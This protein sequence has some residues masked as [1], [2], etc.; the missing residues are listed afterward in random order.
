MLCYQ[1]RFISPT[2]PLTSDRFAH[3]VVSDAV[4][5]TISEVRQLKERAREAATRGEDPRPAEAA[6]QQ[7]KRTLPMIIWQ[8]TFEETVSKRGNRGRWRKQAAARLNGLYMVDIDHVEQP[9]QLFASWWKP[10]MD[11]L[12][13]DGNFH[14]NG[15]GM[16]RW[17]EALGVLLVHVTPSGHGL[18]LVAKAS[19]LRGNLSDNQHWLCSQ[20]GTECDEAC[21][22][23]SRTSFCPGF[24]DILYIDN[25]QLFNYENPEYDEKF[26]PEYRKG[27]SNPSLSPRQPAAAAGGG[28]AEGAA[29]AAAPCADG[30]AESAGLGGGADRQ[31]GRLY[32]GVSYE[33]II[34][35]WFRQNGGEP[36]VGE[37]HTKLLKL[38]GDLRYICDANAA[39]VAW[40]ITQH[41]VGAAYAQSDRPDLDALASSACERQMW[42]STPRRFRAVLTA[43]GVQLPDEGK[44]G[45]AEA[46]PAA[47]Y[48]AYARRLL[49]L[50]EASP[51]LREAVVTIPDR[52]K[53]GGVLAATAMLGTYLT[54]TW[55][56]HFDGRLYRLSF[57]TY[58]VGA[59]ASGKSF[60]TDLDR[61]LMA[62]LQAA[63]KVGRA[64]EQHYKEEQRRR[65]ASEK[66]PEQPHPVIRYC[67]SSTSNAILYRR[68]QDAIDKNVTDPTTGEPL[69]L[70]L[71]TV[72]SELATALRA[73]VGNWAGK[74][75]L[76]LK[77]FHNELAGVDYANAD[78]QNGIMQVNWNQVVSGTQE[79][80]SRK[81]RPQTVLDG[82]VTRLSLFLM[83]SNDYQ[84]L[85]RRRYVRDHEREC[86]LRQLGYRLEEIS[87]ELHAPRLVQFCYDYEEQLTRRAALEQDKC[88]DY[89][90]KRIPVIMMR[91]ALV[92]MVLRQMDALRKGEDLVERD[93]DL[94]YARLIGD[95]CLE[96]QMTMFGQMVMDALEREAATFT[97][98]R[99]KTKTR[100][101]YNA[102]PETFTRQDVMEAGLAKNDGTARNVLSR[103]QKDG[104]IE[105]TNN[106][107]FKKKIHNL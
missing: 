66:L 28:G 45:A 43:A 98:R 62:P 103:W 73:Q 46:A 65:K 35:E 77:S 68:L 88:L 27:H 101:A 24:E 51:G 40:A 56:E 79:S 105:S 59:A 25:Q 33:K 20:L 106:N 44:D 55:W 89:F 2:E 30:D 17:A 67:P 53:L 69:H 96:M 81:I 83:P 100:E 84:M 6:A 57:L 38:A 18:R 99:V 61:L 48:D 13:L 87:G 1:Q 5:K 37:R 60:L 16:R 12:L 94:E 9:E 52:L 32:R 4:V 75:D 47:D 104:F 82:L 21:K 102:L 36:A 107:M 86:M 34:T 10:A 19:L 63:D 95:W 29:A 7:R 41:P 23:A 54:R 58:I 26:G 97:P 74:N 80:M 70:H 72:E 31:D 22:D 14:Q 92:R 39:R 93:D 71:I 42:T 8:A 11:A 85:E 50:L 90:R 3:L 78:S 91:H 49:P 64:A 76:E 15:E